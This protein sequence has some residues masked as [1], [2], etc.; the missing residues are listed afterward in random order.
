MIYIGNQ[1]YKSPD[2]SLI[3]PDSYDAEIEWLGTTEEPYTDRNQGQYIDTG[4]YGTMDLDFEI[5]FLYTQ[6]KTTQG[7]NEGTIFGGRTEYNQNGY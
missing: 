6:L 1:R 2:K 4:L 3:V 5:K 7:V